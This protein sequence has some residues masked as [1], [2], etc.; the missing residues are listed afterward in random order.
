MDKTIYMPLIGEGTEC[1]RPVRATPISDEIF[2][3]VDRIPADGSWA[4]APESR[5][6]CRNHVFTNGETGLVAFQYAVENDPH[7]LFLKSHEREVF[8][9]AF[10]HG[11]EA[12]VKVVNVDGE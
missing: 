8:R 12:V 7:Y 4:F 11:V 6:R 3:V 10:S 9:V 1:W 5:V 2:R